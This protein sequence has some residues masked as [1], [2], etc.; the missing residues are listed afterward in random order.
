MPS[1][2]STRAR[3]L[4]A[5]VDRRPARR[6]RRRRPRAPAPTAPRSATRTSAPGTPTR[7]SSATRGTT[8][9]TPRAAWA[10]T[11]SPVSHDAGRT[12]GRRLGGLGGARPERDRDLEAERQRG[13]P[14]RGAATSRS[15]WAVRRAARRR[16]RRP[17]ASCERFRWSGAP[18]RTFAA[19]LRCRRRSGC[20][21]GRGGP[22][23]RQAARAAP[24]RSRRP[25]RFGW[26]GR[27]SPPEAGA[28]CRPSPRRPPTSAAAFG[29]CS[30][31]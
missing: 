3:A 12:Q 25:R 4:L 18:T 5:V 9:P 29:A 24:R 6:S 13:G 22:G 17:P 10:A 11:G 2:T 23:S 1:P 16:S 14:S 15:S 27:C 31:R 20:G 30:S 21:R 19:R 8:C 26:T 7:P 28:A